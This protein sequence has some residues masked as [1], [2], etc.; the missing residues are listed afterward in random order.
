MTH[1]NI[2]NIIEPGKSS[3]YVEK[4]AHRKEEDSIS[5][6]NTEKLTE[7]A[8]QQQVEFNREKHDVWWKEG[9]MI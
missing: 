1:I 5:N 3:K 8:E 2:V 9:E 7:G 6:K 4:P